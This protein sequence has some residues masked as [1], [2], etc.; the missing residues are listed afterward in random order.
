V[1]GG[2]FNPTIKETGP[3]TG[4]FIKTIETTDDVLESG[5]LLVAK[6]DTI[7]SFDP[8]LS[9]PKAPANLCTGPNS[10]ACSASGNNIHIEWSAVLFNTDDSPMIDLAGY[11]VY[12]KV[13]KDS[14]SSVVKDFG[15]TPDAFV[16]PTTT[17]ADLKADFGNLAQ[18]TYF[19]KVTAFDTCSTPNES[20]FSNVANEP[21]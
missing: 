8:C 16:G 7:T 17:A 11:N 3:A 15:S 14:D 13:V 2:T 21:F 9:T 4:T 10:T 5:K 12:I 6:T 1:A 19:F 20:G 18:H